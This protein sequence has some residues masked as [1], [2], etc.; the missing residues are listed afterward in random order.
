MLDELLE[1]AAV[2][3]ERVDDLVA[4]YGPADIAY[5]AQEAA[6]QEH[7]LPV[8]PNHCGALSVYVAY[9]WRRAGFTDAAPV[10]RFDLDEH[11]IGLGLA[12]RYDRATNS[13]RIDARL[14]ASQW[15]LMHELAHA[16][17]PFDAHGPQW[18]ACFVDLV[19]LGISTD[20]AEVLLDKFEDFGVDVD[21][22]WL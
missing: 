16:A 21:E 13:I 11:A 14:A 15:L 5:R 6:E 8:L 19:R 3:R 17:R 20:A 10:V 4:A 9:V 12:A 18:A 7:E 1:E 2:T 22:S